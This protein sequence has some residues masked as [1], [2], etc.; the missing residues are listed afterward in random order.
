MSNHQQ[1]LLQQ[2][3]LGHS[4]KDAQGP[5]CSPQAHSPAPAISSGALCRAQTS[6]QLHFTFASW[7][8][9][10]E[11]LTYLVSHSASPS[12]LQPPNLGG[13]MVVTAPV[14][15]KAHVSP[16]HSISIGVVPGGQ[17]LPPS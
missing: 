5:S 13:T 8:T 3:S 2:S 11:G 6:A 7:G 10:R 16:H 17:Q 9:F 4:L 1:H 14:P 15:S 12:C